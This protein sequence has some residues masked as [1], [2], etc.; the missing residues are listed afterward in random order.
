MAS[1]TDPVPGRKF[2]P[3][4]TAA[5]GPFL[6]QSVRLRDGSS[7]KLRM[8][9]VF[10]VEESQGGPWQIDFSGDWDDARERAV[11]AILSMA[12]GSGVT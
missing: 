12:C 5:W 4:S 2:D 6:K 8:S 9:L 7:A 10:G 1:L 3:G 11:Y